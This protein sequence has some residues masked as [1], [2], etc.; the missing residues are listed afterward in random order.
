MDWSSDY[1]LENNL[2]SAKFELNSITMLE[3]FLSLL[4][5]GPVSFSYDD[6]SSSQSGGV[7]MNEHLAIP[8][9]LC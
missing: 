5:F 8:I 6:P 4:V 1:S 3:L 2:A 9:N 7:S